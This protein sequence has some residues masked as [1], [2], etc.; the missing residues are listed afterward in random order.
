MINFEMPKFKTASEGMAIA[1][2]MFGKP[3]NSPKGTMCKWN[4]FGSEKGVN[5]HDAKEFVQKAWSLWKQ[6]NKWISAGDLIMKGIDMEK[7]MGVSFTQT[8]LR[9]LFVVAPKAR[10]GQQNFVHFWESLVKICD[11]KILELNTGTGRGTNQ[12]SSSWVSRVRALEERVLFLEEKLLLA[13]KE[14]NPEQKTFNTGQFYG[15]TP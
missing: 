12:F 14:K 11:H 5:P 4:S 6:E 8:L 3:E 2:T 9:K 15:N 13:E 1:R 7:F 10:K